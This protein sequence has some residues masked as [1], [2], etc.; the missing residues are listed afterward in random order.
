MD[1][2]LIRHAPAVKRSPGR[3]DAERRL[4][5]RGAERWRRSVAGLR[6]LGVR[7][8]RLYHSPWARAVETAEAATPLLD[9]QRVVTDNLASPPGPDLLGELKGKRVALV[10]HEP[11]LSQL[12]AW[13]VLDDRDAAPKFV[14]K[15]GCVAWLSGQPKPGQME[16]NALLPPKTLRA[17]KRT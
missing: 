17:L 1:L 3:D 6:S 11:W 16:L 8:D 10:G 9:G 2:F 14:L 15:K 4:T 12:L 13:L 5:G 7:F